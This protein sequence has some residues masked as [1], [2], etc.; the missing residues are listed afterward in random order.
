M[1]V[2]GVLSLYRI[3]YMKQ[4]VNNCLTINGI[5]YYTAFASKL[6]VFYVSEIEGYVDR[7]LNEVKQIEK[8]S[9]AEYKTACTENGELY[10]LSGDTEGIAYKKKHL[11]EKALS[12]ACL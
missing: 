9:E 3:T 2:F 12:L 4:F 8:E 6:V 5:L 11:E 10:R 1:I 7:Y